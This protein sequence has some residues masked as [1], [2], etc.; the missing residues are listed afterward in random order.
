MVVG[1]TF[2]IFWRLFGSCISSEP[3]VACTFH[4]YI[5]NSH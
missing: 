5:L 4:T 2:T 3:R 1:A